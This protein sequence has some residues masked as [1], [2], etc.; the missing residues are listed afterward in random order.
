LEMR[1]RAGA[2]AA[3]LEIRSGA[4]VLRGQI[5]ARSASS[6]AVGET[7]TIDRGRKTRSTRGTSD[8]A[9][10]ELEGAGAGG[11]G[12]GVPWG[13]VP[14]NREKARIGCGNGQSAEDRAESRGAGARTRSPATS[15]QAMDRG[16]SDFAFAGQ[17][18]GGKH[19]QQPQQLA[20]LPISNISQTDHQQRHQPSSKQQTPPAVHTT[21]SSRNPSSC[22][23]PH[24]THTF[25]QVARQAAR[26]VVRRSNP[27]VLRTVCSRTRQPGRGRGKPPLQSQQKRMLGSRLHWGNPSRGLPL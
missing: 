20:N 26:Q 17:G 22:T 7:T 12:P 27:V 9:D 25:R 3:A 21:A 16:A 10:D 13:G 4:G 1:R 14:R 2:G 5:H 19:Q 11:W 6:N 15:K 24:Q 18:A 23:S 8:G